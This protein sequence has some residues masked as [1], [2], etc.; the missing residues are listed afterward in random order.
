MNVSVV[1]PSTAEHGNIDLEACVF[2]EK[3]QEELEIFF[4]YRV[5]LG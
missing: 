2:F 4:Y 5:V 1:K 3:N